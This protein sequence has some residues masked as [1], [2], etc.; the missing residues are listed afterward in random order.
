MRNSWIRLITL[1][2]AAALHCGAPA[3][4]HG[5][6]EPARNPVLT[7]LTI[8]LEE[9]GVS[10]DAGGFPIDSPDSSV[11]F[12]LRWAAVASPSPSPLT[13]PS[14]DPTQELTLV[15][16]RIATG[17]A[18]QLRGL[19]LATDRL[20]VAA[21]DAG[22]ALR[23]WTVVAD[24]RIVRAESFGPDGAIQGEDL[25]RPDADLFVTIPNDTAVAALRVYQTLWDGQAFHLT[26][27]GAVPVR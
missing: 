6:Q 11:E 7:Q 10:V 23:S 22:N 19:R 24:P 26:S 4:V 8:L 25:Y 20:F 9:V 18:P 16:R 1:T 12:H 21:V 17:P 13:N 15:T 2:C 14:A 27:V 3:P 5:A